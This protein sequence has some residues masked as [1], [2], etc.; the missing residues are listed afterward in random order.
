MAVAQV[1]KKYSACYADQNFLV[2]FIKFC[3]WA[4][5]LSTRNQSAISQTTRSSIRSVLILSSS[6][7]R[8]DFFF[9][10]R[11]EKCVGFIISS[12]HAISSPVNFL[13]NWWIRGL[14]GKYP[15]ILNISRTVRVTLMQLGTQRRPYCASMNSYSPVGLVSRQWDAAGWACVRVTVAFRMTERAD[16]LHHDNAPAHS[17][18]FALFWPSITS[19]RSVSPPQ[20]IFGSLRLLAFPKSKVAIEREEICE[21]D[22]HTVPKLS[23]RRRSVNDVSLP[24]D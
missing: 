1:I 2:G 16:K 6:D 15:A 23:Q 3:R 21:F 9:V 8:S 22:G 24:T 11:P 17:T 12:T 20:P 18:A 19:S 10:F 14:F 13:T 4:L 7:F 5:S